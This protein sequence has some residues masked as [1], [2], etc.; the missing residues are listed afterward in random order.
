MTFNP[1]KERGIPLDRQL[2]DF[3]HRYRYANL[4][5]CEV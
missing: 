5:A 1:F 2:E 4:T 3:D